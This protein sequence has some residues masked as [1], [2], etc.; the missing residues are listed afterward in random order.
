MFLRFLPTV[1]ASVA[2]LW[3]AA[4]IAMPRKPLPHNEMQ[5][6]VYT[7]LLGGH[8]RVLLLAV[9]GTVIGLLV[10]VL[11]MPSSVTALSNRTTSRQQ[12]CY[13]GGASPTCY[14]PQPGGA[15]LEEELQADGTWRVVGT[16]FVAP[17]AP[18]TNSDRDGRKCT[19]GASQY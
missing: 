16:S 18:G 12:V 10:L 1:S 7:R 6:L 13:H 5:E 17:Q 2:S 15:W 14:T 4:F 19:N 3:I 9:V 11:S 8:H